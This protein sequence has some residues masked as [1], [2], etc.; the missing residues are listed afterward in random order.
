MDELIAE[1][2][3]PAWWFTA[4]LVALLINVIA[5]YAK[6]WLDKAI[7]RLSHWWA[8]SS[9]ERSRQREQWVEAIATSDLILEHERHRAVT[10]KLNSLWSLG[11]FVLS[12]VFPKSYAVAPAKSG[13]A[14][15][16]LGLI[17]VVLAFRSKIRAMLIDVAILDALALRAKRSQEKS[18]KE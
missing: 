11:F 4:V 17:F 1:V 3:K 2:G 15:M 8:D 18:R 13:S 14:F 7:A 5:G 6:D 9:A 12:V 10:L 16:L